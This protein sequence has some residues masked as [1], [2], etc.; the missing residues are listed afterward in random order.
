MR[1]P[2]VSE[3]KV[4]LTMSYRHPNCLRDSRCGFYHIQDFSGTVQK[5]LLFDREARLTKMYHGMT[6][7]AYLLATFKAVQYTSP[8]CVM[9]CELVQPLLL[10]RSRVYPFATQSLRAI[11]WIFRRKLS[12]LLIPKRPGSV[13]GI[14]VR[15]MSSLE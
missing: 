3:P 15:Y 10:L 13:D 8:L 2:F 7:D 6:M 12:T 5:F 11:G 9:V 1:L 4:P 14:W